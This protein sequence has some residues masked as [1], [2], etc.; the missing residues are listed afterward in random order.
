M[1]FRLRVDAYKLVAHSHRVS[2]QAHAAIETA[3]CDAF[4]R[5]EV[6]CARAV[7]EEMLAWFDDCEAHNALRIHLAWTARTCH[8]AKE[9]IATALTESKGDAA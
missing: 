6:V 4:G 9:T 2:T 1:Q 8:Q 3:T 7:A 5:Y